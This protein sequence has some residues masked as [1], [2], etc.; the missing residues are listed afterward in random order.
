M[1]S[2]RYKDPTLEHDLTSRTKPW[3]LSPFIAAMPYLA[4]AR[5]DALHTV[6]P[7]PPTHPLQD[8]TS[9]M[10]FLDGSIP[11]ELKANAATKRRAYFGQVDTRSGVVLGPEVRAFIVIRNIYVSSMHD[12]ETGR[13]NR[14]LLPWPSHVQLER[15]RF[16]ATGRIR[17]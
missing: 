5:T 8:N 12:V 10:R 7:F 6:P 17:I 3:V 16:A 14:R 9:G 1:R 11:A 2:P 13:N 15:H 4:H